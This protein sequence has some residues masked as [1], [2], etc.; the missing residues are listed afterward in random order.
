MVAT[1]KPRSRKSRTVSKYFSMYSLRPWK[2]QTVP[3]RLAGGD[4]RANR[5]SAPSGVLIVP[6]TAS[7]GTGLAGIE[8]SDMEPTRGRK[9]AAKSKG[10][11]G[12]TGV[13]SP[14]N[15]ER[16]LPYH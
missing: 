2:M 13:Q 6:E 15:D 16:A 14:L 5:I 7:S 11:M 9:I 4:Q 1:A 10:T 8:T 3:L 12:W